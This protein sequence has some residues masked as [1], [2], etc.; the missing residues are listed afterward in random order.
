[1]CGCKYSPASSPEQANIKQGLQVQLWLRWSPP[2]YNTERCVRMQARGGVQRVLYPGEVADQET[3]RGRQLCR[4][5]RQDTPRG[6]QY[7]LGLLFDFKEPWTL[8]NAFDTVSYA[9]V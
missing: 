8:V 4:Q 5:E 9:V 3:P 7:G 2:A 6:A 1:M